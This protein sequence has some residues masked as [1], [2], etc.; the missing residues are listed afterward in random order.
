[1]SN[2]I[3]P[4]GSE[5]KQDQFIKDLRMAFYANEATI[6]GKDATETKIFDALPPRSW[7]GIDPRLRDIER[8]SAPIFET[9]SKNSR[10]IDIN[11]EEIEYWMSKDVE[12]V[13]RRKSLSDL[14][15]NVPKVGASQTA[16]REPMVALGA[17]WKMSFEQFN[18]DRSK[19]TGQLDMM[20]NR[21]VLRQITE[22]KDKIALGGDATITTKDG[23]KAM[24][25]LRNSTGVIADTPAGNLSTGGGTAWVNTLIKARQLFIHNDIPLGANRRITVLCNDEDFNELAKDYSTQYIQTA[26]QRLMS[27]GG[28]ESFVPAGN[29]NRNEMICVIN[30]PEFISVPE[31]LKTTMIPLFRKDIHQDFEFEYRCKFGI[32]VHRNVNNQTGV[33]RLT[34]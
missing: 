11:Y 25:G 23:S 22:D 17:G 20:T 5:S 24:T 32:V 28:F 18:L 13:T 31:G 29:I 12:G 7:I 3:T 15:G 9:L 2:Y 26:E 33:L 21:H 34:S 14:V 1:M 6:S 10:T 8:D 19:N 4:Q 27:V 30:T 16:A